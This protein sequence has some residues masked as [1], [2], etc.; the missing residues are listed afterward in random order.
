MSSKASRYTG[1]APTQFGH[2][3]PLQL[4]TG[5]AKDIIV[6]IIGCVVHAVYDIA[7][8]SACLTIIR[9]KGTQCINLRL[10]NQKFPEI[11]KEEI[12]A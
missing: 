8:F 3:T 6:T 12:S 5:V 2:T 7:R 9:G 11:E 10:R 1:T 4:P